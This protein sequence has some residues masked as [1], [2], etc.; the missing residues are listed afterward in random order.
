MPGVWDTPPTE[1]E[2]A[3][4]KQAPSG[5]WDSPPTPE[6][7]AQAPARP[8]PG[9]AES[10]VRGGVEAIPFGQ[11]ISALGTS[12]GLKLVKALSSNPAYQDIDDSYSEAL[13]RERAS[14]DAA[15]EAHPIATVGGGIVGGGAAMAALPGAA[16]AAKGA[17][18]GGRLAAS[19][20]N[21]ARYGAL[22]GAGQGDTLKEAIQKAGDEALLMGALGAGGHLVGE[23][24]GYVVKKGVDA[25]KGA[26]TVKPSADAKL[27]E[28]AGVP[29]TTGQ[30]NPTSSIGAIEE[31]AVD[32][33]G[34]GAAV[35]SQ[36]EA[37]VQKWREK[38]LEKAL[39]PGAKLPAGTTQEQLAGVFDSFDGAYR[40]IKPQAIA[41]VTPEGVPLGEA[42][43]RA[44]DNVDTVPD[45][46]RRNVARFVEKRMPKLRDTRDVSFGDLSKPDNAAK[47]LDW[48]ENEGSKVSRVAE[49]TRA[50]GGR[51][52]KAAPVEPDVAEAGDL[53]AFRSDV[54]KAIRDA[55]Q[56]GRKDDV[57]AYRAAEKT[58]TEVLEPQLTPKDAKLLRETDRAYALYNTIEKAARSG[59][60]ES[61]FS[62]RQL[63]SALLS[64]KGQ[65]AVVQGR[66]GE[67]QELARAGA[68]V[69]D[70]NAPRT[71]ARLL[72]LL[73]DW[74]GGKLAH[75]TAAHLM[76]KPGVRAFLL[77]EPTA[78]GFPTGTDGAA[79]AAVL[80]L[81]RDVR[82]SPGLSAAAAEEDRR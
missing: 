24:V 34:V 52:A 37:A 9:A 22:H 58:L 3:G 2:L 67:L 21:A 64:T 44:I 8:N 76:N 70:Q 81:L 62:P 43:R 78:F 18:L 53:I 77:R 38:V 71:G 42:L 80:R 60:P 28:K 65:R 47:A 16:Q 46:V 17:G 5:V 15:R 6:E 72:T 57:Q 54:R 55:R 4:Q 36:R 11:K 66:G 12:L 35:Q 63:H 20:A 68:A 14:Y 45:D 1:A 39:P 41:P 7:L 25:A 29:L 50:E 69:F 27:L 30:M 73:P 23:G 19:A 49:G 61:T 74:M 82:A 79:R 26:L 33:P 51:V 40:Q 10:F 48:L 13:R 75:G 31:T 59:G 56:A 32:L